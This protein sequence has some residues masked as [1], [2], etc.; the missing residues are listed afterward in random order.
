MLWISAAPELSGL[1]MASWFFASGLVIS[2]QLVGF[3]GALLL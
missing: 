1:G 2:A 3:S